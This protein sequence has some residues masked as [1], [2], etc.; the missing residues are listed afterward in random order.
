MKETQ[1]IFFS[2]A[3]L[4][5]MPLVHAGSS[6]DETRTMSMDGLVQVENLAGSIKITGWDK[7]EVKISGKLGDDVEDFEVLETSSGIQIRVHNRKNQRNV[8]ES[9]LELHIPAAASIEAES[10]SAEI[11][12]EAMQGASVVTHSVSG[13]ITLEASTE[14]LEAESVSGDVTF[15]GGSPRSSVETVSGEIDLEGIVG[16]IKISTVSGDVKLAGKQINLGRFETVSGEL[17]MD[18]DVPD[19]GRLNAESMSGDVH[20][21]L[22]AGQQAE[23]T[24]QTYSGDIRSDFGT[25]SGKSHGAGSSLSHREA[26]NG[27]SIRIESFSGDIHISGR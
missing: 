24:A 2:V 20:L 8:D 25:V 13:D 1:N 6:I 5:F 18:L 22:P 17:E 3:I 27:A 14:V 9:Y 16:E 19:G 15:R 21:V 26:S 11:S 12:V 10:V 7:T 4:L 23:Y